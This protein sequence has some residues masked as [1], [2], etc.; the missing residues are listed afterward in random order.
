MNILISIVASLLY[1][2]KRDRIQGAETKNWW[3]LNKERARP[4][5][6]TLFNI[7]PSAPTEREKNKGVDPLYK[8]E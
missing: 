8:R 6:G 7:P 3:S 2:Y 4:K 1:T 5:C